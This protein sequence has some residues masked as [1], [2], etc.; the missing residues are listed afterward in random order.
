MCFKVL[1]RLTIAE[2]SI[3]EGETKLL[4]IKENTKVTVTEL[5]Y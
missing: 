4:Q 3:K 1:G 5:I 2:V